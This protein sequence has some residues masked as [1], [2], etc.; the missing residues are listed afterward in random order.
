M[1]LRS[2]ACAECLINRNNAL[3][4]SVERAVQMGSFMS[5]ILNNAKHWR[6]RAEET[7]LVADGIHRN[8]LQNRKLLRLAEE[9]EQLAKRAEQCQAAQVEQQ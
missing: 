1:C 8:E 2:H 9:Y 7:R 5:E 3:F 4:A 6:G